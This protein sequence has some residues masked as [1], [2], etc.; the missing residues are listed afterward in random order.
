LRLKLVYPLFKKRLKEKM[1]SLN[2]KKIAL[3]IA[4]EDF[5]DEEYF[6][7]KGILEKHEAEIYTVSS[8]KGT[9]I[10][11][12]GGEVEINLT[13]DEFRVNGFDA[14]ILIGGPGAQKYFENSK[15]HQ[16]VQE[17]VRKDKVVGAICIAP[18]ILA[19]AGV[20]KGKSA[21]VWFS[22]L[23]KSAVKILEENGAIFKDQHINVVVDGKII[24]ANGPAAA[25]EFTEEI[26]KLLS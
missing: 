17:A 12:Q 24:T 10:G 11:T 16:I 19:K 9:A 4:F 22:P 26:I 23:D 3:I 15:I 18:A 1:A 5:R 7:P 20:L 13:F 14:V 8:E 25:Q 2:S 6:I 21:T